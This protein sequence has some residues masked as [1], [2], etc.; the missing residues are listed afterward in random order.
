MVD[1]KWKI[2]R[3]EVMPEIGARHSPHGAER[4]GYNAGAV[5]APLCGAPG[6]SAAITSNRA[7][8]CHSPFR[9]RVKPVA[10]VAMNGSNSVVLSE[11]F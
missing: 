11:F 7:R 6:A 8:T 10:L 1:E 5:A 4:R 9:N 2:S 3:S